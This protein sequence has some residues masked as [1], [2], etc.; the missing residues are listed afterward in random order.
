[1]LSNIVTDTLEKW[2][3]LRFKNVI[4]DSDVDESSNREFNSRIKGR[5]N[6]Y[7]I[8]I[9]E[10][11]MVFGGYFDGKIENTEMWNYG[12]KQFIFTMNEFGKKGQIKKCNQK[13]KS[14]IF[15]TNRNDNMLYTFYYGFGIAKPYKKDSYCC[16][17][18]NKW[19]EDIDNKT[20]NNI[21]K[22]D[23]FQTKRILV[24]EMY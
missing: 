8:N 6:L 21:E 3:H 12:N 17:N 4:F 16:P 13:K 9:D 1:M 7:F 14:G 5:S 24:V 19:Y 10:N 22:Y 23:K 20:L 11:G 15:I 2:S 18:I